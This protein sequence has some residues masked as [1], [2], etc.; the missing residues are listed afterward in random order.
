MNLHREDLD[1]VQ[2][3]LSGDR[4]AFER[5]FEDYFPRLFR[6]VLRR[7]DRDVESARDVVQSTL[8]KAIRNLG[9]YR[10]EASL[11]TWLCQIARHEYSDLRMRQQAA[12]RTVV[13]LE[14][15]PSV[16]AALESLRWAEDAEPPQAIE[17]EQRDEL[18]HATLDYLPSR[19]AKLLE[20]KY[21][22]ELP[23]DQIAQRMGM[24][25]IAVQS[26]LARARAAFREAHEVLASG[27]AD[28]KTRNGRL[29]AQESK[30]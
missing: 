16:R 13:A 23:V 15:D 20:M 22:D 10:G 8:L 3:L 29:K 21:V 7:A 1:Q 26:L 17:R 12:D 9:A 30:A 24:T 27:L 6:F 19:Y 25:A 28:L 5:F 2:L 14:N 11:F 4:A 18:V